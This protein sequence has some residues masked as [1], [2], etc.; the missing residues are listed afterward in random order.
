MLAQTF[1][2][3]QSEPNSTHLCA[4]SSPWASRVQ[5]LDQKMSKVFPISKRIWPC[6]RLSLQSVCVWLSVLFLLQF[7]QS[8]RGLKCNCVYK[9]PEEFHMVCRMWSW[10]NLKRLNVL[11][12]L[13]S[14]LFCKSMQFVDGRPGMDELWE[15]QLVWPVSP[16]VGAQE[17]SQVAATLRNSHLVLAAP[18]THA[19]WLSLSL[20]VPHLLLNFISSFL[21][22][23]LS[24]FMHSEAM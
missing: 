24:I 8:G 9:H 4:E 16:V 5:P 21:I 12:Q 17:A 22:W 13:Q 14:C 15:V 10:L 3:T 20:T 18:H 7:E 23:T 11:R 1:S 19:L 2:E 6:G